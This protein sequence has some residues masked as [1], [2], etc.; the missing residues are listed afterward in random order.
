M[1]LELREPRARGWRWG[2]RTLDFILR[3]L[4]ELVCD[5]EHQPQRLV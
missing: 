5:S 3:V 1:L 2:Q 4:G